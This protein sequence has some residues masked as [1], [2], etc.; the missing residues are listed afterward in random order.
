MNLARSYWSKGH[1]GQWDTGILIEAMLLEATLFKVML[2]KV[3]LF[4][5]MLLKATLHTL[6]LCRGDIACQFNRST[7]MIRTKSDN[8][9][10]DEN[11]D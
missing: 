7:Q 9:N 10:D 8:Q 11:D 1:T 5:V 2:F 3:M 6:T 4:K